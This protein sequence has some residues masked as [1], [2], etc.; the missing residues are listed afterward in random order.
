MKG[1]KN[2]LNKFKAI[3]CSATLVLAT[4]VPAMGVS[5]ASIPAIEDPETAPM[6]WTVFADDS[7]PFTD[8]GEGILRISSSAIADDVTVNTA[9]KTVTFKNLKSG[10]MDV[11]ANGWT[12]IF[13]G[14]NVIETDLVIEDGVTD[15]TIEVLSGSSLTVKKT[16]Y[17]IV[18]LGEDT[19]SDVEIETES[20]QHTGSYETI[21][22]PDTFEELDE[23]ITVE[24]TYDAIATDGPV[25]FSNSKDASTENAV[26]E[27]KTTEEV[28]TNEETSAASEVTTPAADKKDEVNEENKE[29]I[30]IPAEESNPEPDYNASYNNELSST[31]SSIKEAKAG[32]VVVLESG[33]SLPSYIMAALKD[34][35]NATLRFKYTYQDVDYDITITGRQAAKVFNPAIEWYGPVWLK[36]HIK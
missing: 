36:K 29:E 13:D 4:I 2:Y 19:V 15:A 28:K 18:K 24:Y 21:F 20:K 8:N 5:A 12:L 22:D 14:T 1:Y 16:I 3:A 10:R 27:T 17:N 25:K 7:N 11:D 33:D 26:E 23:P 9:D 32:E 30:V 35:P 6:Q 34:N 31:S